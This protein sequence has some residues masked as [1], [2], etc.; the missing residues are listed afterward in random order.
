MNTVLPYTVRSGTQPAFADYLIFRI[1]ETNTHQIYDTGEIVGIIQ[2]QFSTRVNCPLGLIQVAQ[3]II[4]GNNQITSVFFHI[5]FR[6][7]GSIREFAVCAVFFF[8]FL[9]IMVIELIQ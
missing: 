7:Y 9:I 8:C 4:G 6:K 1:V 5:Q 2:S 3:F